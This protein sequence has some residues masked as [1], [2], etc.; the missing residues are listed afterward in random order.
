M[1][2]TLKIIYAN[3]S[4][5]TRKWSETTAV[6]LCGWIVCTIVF[7]GIYCSVY[8]SLNLHL[9][10]HHHR[11]RRHHHRHQYLEACSPYHARAHDSAIRASATNE[12]IKCIYTTN[13]YS[14]TK[15]HARR[16]YVRTHALAHQNSNMHIHIYDNSTRSKIHKMI[17]DT[18]KLYYLH[19]NEIL[20][21]ILRYCISIK[22]KPTQL[23]PT[24]TVMPCFGGRE[25]VVVA[26]VAVIVLRT[27]MI[28]V[29]WIRA[30]PTTTTKTQSFTPYI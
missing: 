30:A 20:S 26:V 19:W 14:R 18:L 11:H 10:Q 25:R 2:K 27:T 4:H 9:H 8:I 5:Y 29:I 7:G 21:I 3:T 6:Q 16:T 23:N 13:E 17:C 1:A 28:F 15:K 12:I 22:T 24:T